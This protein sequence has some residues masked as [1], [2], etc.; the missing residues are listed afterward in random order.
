M[1]MVDYALHYQRNGFSVIPISSDSKK[2]LVSFADKPPA[3]EITIRRWWRDYPNA[4][5][6]VRTDS[7]FVIDVDM[8]GNVNGLE[9]LRHWN[10]Q[11]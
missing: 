5:I 4:N 6:A 7:F 8:H 9:N 2:P 3:D 1:Q 11:G 10:T